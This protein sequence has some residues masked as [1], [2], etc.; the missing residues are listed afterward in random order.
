LPRLQKGKPFSGSI[1][2]PFVPDQPGLI[3]TT[4]L[5]PATVGRKADKMSA[6]RESQPKRFCYFLFIWE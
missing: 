6:V 3:G 4:D 1:I 2:T 5:H